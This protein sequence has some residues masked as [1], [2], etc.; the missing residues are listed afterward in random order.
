LDSEW[1]NADEDDHDDP[2][3][4]GPNQTWLLLT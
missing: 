2:D 4:E 1:H 3:D